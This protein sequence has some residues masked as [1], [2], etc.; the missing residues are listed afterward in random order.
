MKVTKKRYLVNTRSSTLKNI[1]NATLFFTIDVVF[2]A[3]RSY[4]VS[5]GKTRKFAKI[6]FYFLKSEILCTCK[7]KVTGKRTNFGDDRELRITCLLQFSGPKE[8]IELL[9]KLLK[10]CK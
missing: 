2:L 8:N 4:H 5:K 9:K 6:V 7:V 3:L 1:F 10:E